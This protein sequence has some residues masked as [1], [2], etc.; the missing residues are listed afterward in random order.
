MNLVKI[1][2]ILL[3]KNNID[4]SKWSC[5]ACDQFSSQPKYWAVLTELVGDSPSALNLILPEAY[6]NNNAKQKV[7][8][9]NKNMQLYLDNG[10]FEEVNA[11][12]LVKRTLNNGKI[13]LGLMV[14]ID[15]ERYEYS[16]KNTALIKATEKTVTERLPA[17][18]DIRKNACLEMPH[19]MMLFDDKDSKIIEELYKNRDDMQILYDFDL[20]MNGGHLTGYK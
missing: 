8:Q 4:Y 5:I 1:P 9:I 12:I 13:R 14:E 6:L 11:V 10:L 19:I 2:N 15:L 17:R 20:N 16:D 7:A 3:P 18:I